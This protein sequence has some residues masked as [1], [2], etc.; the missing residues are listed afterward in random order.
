MPTL[1]KGDPQPK[2]YHL[3]DGAM[4]MAK[5]LR[6]ARMRIEL[7]AVEGGFAL[8]TVRRFIRPGDP[9]LYKSRLDTLLRLSETLG[10]APVEILPILGKRPR[11]MGLLN[12]A[13]V[14]P[15][16]RPHDGAKDAQK[17]MNLEDLD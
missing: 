12:K 10:C 4:P 11:K 1:K 3:R 16:R 6:A 9:N 7:V 2:P 17:E 15:F 8:G 14:I 5:M 13:G